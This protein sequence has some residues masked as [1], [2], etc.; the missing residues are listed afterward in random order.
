MATNEEIVAAAQQ[1]YVSYYGR[2]ADPEGLAFWIEEF[3]NS[4]NVDQVLIDFGTS[5]EFLNE[6]GDLTTSELITALYQ[7]MFNRDPDAEGLAFYTD[8]LDS[9]EASLASIALD[10]ANGATGDDVTIL[11]NKVTVANA[12]T[13][14]V[15]AKN[16]LY[17][18]SDIAGA[19]ALLSAVDESDASVTA[20]IAA[21]DDFTDALPATVPGG[22]YTLDEDNPVADYSA[23]TGAVFVTLDCKVKPGAI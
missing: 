14:D 9:G 15:E 21:A 19:K 2:P 16:S 8:L 7:Q 12:F 5:E 6:Y 1:L 22:E 20:G 10:I 4:D 13:A 23:A 17:Q 3:T 18:A 11:G